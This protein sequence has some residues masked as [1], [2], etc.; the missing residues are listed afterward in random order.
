MQ[1]RK[2]SVSS[3]NADFPHQWSMPRR[4]ELFPNLIDHGIFI[5]FFTQKKL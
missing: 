1:E 5:V 4:L 3:R 2:Q